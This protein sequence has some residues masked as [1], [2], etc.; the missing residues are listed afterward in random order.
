ME[1]LLADAEKISGVKYDISSFADISEAIHVVQTEMGI[2]GTT[3]KE[4]STTIQGSI[5]SMKSAWQNLMTG[6]SDPNQDLGVLITNFVDTGVTA[7]GNII[8]RIVELMPRIADALQ[9][10]VNKVVPLI[11]KLLNSL[12]PALIQGAIALVNGVVL[13]LPKIIEALINALPMFIDGIVQIFNGIIEALPELMQTICDALPSLLPQLINGIISAI[14]TLCENFGAIIQ[15]IINVLPDIIMS[16]V[17]ALLNNLPALINGVVQ[18]VIGIVNSVG[19]IIEKLIPMIP[20]IIQAIVKALIESIPV[21]LSA[22]LEINIAI[23]GYMWSFV[24]GIWNLLVEGWNNITEFI[25]AIPLWIY[26]CIIAIPN[27]FKEKIINPISNLFSNLANG[28]K[29]IWQGIKDFFKG[30]INGIIGGINGMIRGVCNGI[31]FVIRAM[32]KVSFDIPEW[33]PV[34]GGKKFGFD[35]GEI[36]APQIPLLEKGAVLEKGQK[37]FIEGNGA[38]AVVPLENNRKWISAVANDMERITNQSETNSKILTAIE[39]LTDIIKAIDPNVDLYLDGDTLV[40]GTV[41]RINEK[42]GQISAIRRRGAT[43]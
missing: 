18:L 24:E 35:L 40:G 19:L 36:T 31:N 2:T 12:L 17:N 39:N 4:A 38:E 15:P 11:P 27:W 42:L 28:V 33:V 9:T 14:I 22:I 1:R 30:I 10:I 37:G 21:I 5:G 20:D 8:P 7:L 34:V 16:I 3:A 25:E 41:N 32:N 23:L 29:S 6:L 26:N 43:V 13:A